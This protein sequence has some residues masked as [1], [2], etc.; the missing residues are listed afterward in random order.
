V[1]VTDTGIGIAPEQHKAVFEA[2]QQADGS[3]ARKYGGTGLGLSISRELARLL[4]G[5]IQLA[6]APDQ[7]STF[8]LYLPVALSADHREPAQKATPTAGPR[9]DVSVS[10]DPAKEKAAAIEIE[11]DRQSL[12]DDDRVMLVVE[13]DPNFARILHQACHE[14]GFKCLAAATGEAGLELAKKHLPGGVILDIRLAG[15]MDGWAVLT[16]LK[17][18]IRTRHIPVHIVSV[19]NASAEA[20]R[21]GAVGYATK[22]LAREDLE[23]AFR[24]LEQAAIGTARRV[25]VVEDRADMRRETVKLIGGGDMKVDEAESGKQ[26]LEALRA[27][28]YDCVVLDL[29]LPDMDGLELLKL[30]KSEGREVPPVIIHTA[31]DLTREEEAGL[32]EY[33]ESIVI[34]DVRSKERLLDEVSLFLHRVVSRMPEKERQIIHNLHD[35]DVFLRGKKVLIVDDDMRT[36]FALSRLL[37]ERGMKALKAENGEKALKLLEQEPDVALVLMDIMMPVMDGYEAM[38]RIRAKEKFR[39]LPI[40]VLT[41]KAM[42]DD[43]AKCIAAGANDYLPKPVDPARLISMMRVWLYR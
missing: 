13:D 23:E 5:E 15:G 16:A 33:A 24:K 2:F 26:A 3:T 7:G 4:G 30:L 21:R 20:L 32:R 9:G 37:T 35:T 42:Q 25:L 29:G 31:R 40:I 18:D 12:G 17:D 38:T 8:T 22:P 14:K 43:R 6:S 1:A 27:G 39:R 34:K 41:A 10:R 11:D 36:T 28:H 19:E